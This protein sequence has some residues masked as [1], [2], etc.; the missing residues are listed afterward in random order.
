MA[1]FVIFDKVKKQ[2]ITIQLTM[3][4]LD[5]FFGN[6]EDWF[7]MC[8]SIEERTGIKI[9]GNDLISLDGRPVH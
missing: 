4:E 8:K 1:D 2:D 7:K 9:L 6:D 5:L 3:K